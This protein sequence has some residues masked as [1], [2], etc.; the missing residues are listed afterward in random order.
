[1][2]DSC[3]SHHMSFFCVT[4]RQTLCYNVNF[5]PMAII[6]KLDINICLFVEWCVS[7]VINCTTHHLQ[8]YLLIWPL[9]GYEIKSTWLNFLYEVQGTDIYEKFTNGENKLIF[10]EMMMMRSALY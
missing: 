9:T 6:F 2:W 1:M 3:I 4:M 5:F 10:N 8:Y 7:N